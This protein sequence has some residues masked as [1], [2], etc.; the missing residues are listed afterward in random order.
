VLA[1]GG[2]VHRLVVIQRQPWQAISWPSSLKAAVSS[3]WRCSAMLT[4]NTVS[5]SRALELAQDAPHARARAV[6]IDA[7][8]AHVAAG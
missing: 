7:L 4:P 6:F 5:G 3:G 1:L 2:F 8:H